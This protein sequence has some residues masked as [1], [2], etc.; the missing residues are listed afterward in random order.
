MNKKAILFDVDGV[1]IRGEL[2]GV[3]FQREHGISAAEMRPFYTGVFQDCLTGKADLKEVLTPWLEKWKWTGTPDEFMQAWFDYETV[4]DQKILDFVRSLQEKAIKCY[5]ATNQE[6]Y[7]TQYLRDTMGFEKIFDG[8]FSSADIGSKKPD[9]DFY[10]FVCSTLEKEGINRSEIV[11]TDDS[12]SC[13]ESAKALGIES[14]TYTEFSAFQAYLTQFIET[15]F[16]NR[17]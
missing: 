3:H 11:Y 15:E 17:I 4:V 16:K 6:K 8:V 2:F 14:F 9:A 10:E 5:L 7:R 1:I 12:A 13:V